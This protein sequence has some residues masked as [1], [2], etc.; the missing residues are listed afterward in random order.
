LIDKAIIIPARYQSSRFPGK[1]LIEILGVSMIRRVW[2][3]CI[4]VLPPKHVFVA[5]DSEKILEHCIINNIQVLMT[6]RDCL[7]GT[8]RI[9]EASKQINAKTIINVQGDEPL[10]GAEDILA[11]INASEKNPNK[12]INAMCPI[13]DEKDYKSTNIPKVVCRPDGRLLYMSRSPIPMDKTNKFNQSWKQV[14]IYAFPLQALEQ[15]ANVR[16]KTPLE[17]IED[18]EILRF[19][20][21]G[22]DVNMVKVSSSSISVDIK[23]DVSRVEEEII[24]RS[25]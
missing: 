4:E 19:L 16:D 5:T 20:E 7:T 22:Y 6:S 3:K 2:S 9:Y 10:V 1:P 25:V 17:K 24:A 14:C 21:L 23:E 15:Y 12:V 8:D 18:I 11:V 13:L